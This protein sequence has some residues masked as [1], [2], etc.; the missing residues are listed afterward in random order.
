M[1]SYRARFFAAVLFLAAF[2]A[3]VRP[4]VAQVFA[5][6][7]A[8]NAIVWTNNPVG[9]VSQTWT[10]GM[11]TGFG[12][13][14]PWVLLQT[15][16]DNTHKNFAGF[17]NG[18]G[19]N[20]ATTNSSSWGTF[21]NGN[22]DGAIPLSNGTNKAVAMRGF[23]PLTTNQVFK[24]QW[25]SKGI[26]SG[27]TTNNR[28]GFALRNGMATNSYLDYDIGSRFD[29]YYA[30]GGGSFLIRDGNGITPTGI[31]F[32]SAGFNCEFTPKAGNAYRF[33]IHSA[34]DNSVVYITDGQP[35]AGSGTI[36]S[37][38]CYDL[39]C[40]DGD[41]NF[42]RMQILSTSLIPSIIVNFQPTNG[43]YFVNPAGKISFEVDSQASTVAG[44]G[45][46]L[47]LNG[48]AQALAFNTNGA[49]S[50]LFATNAA[51]LATNVAYLATV[52]ATDA[53]GNSATN[54]F[55][56]NTYQTN[57][58]WM[59]VKT[60][61]ATGNGTTKD[62][63][64]IQ[65]AINACPAGGYV[66]LHNSTFLSGTISLKGNMTLFIDPTATLLGSGSAA[67]YPTQTPP[68]SNS[69]LGNCPR[70]LVYAESCT[71]VTVTGGGTI[72]GNG[73]TNFTSGV[74][75]TRPIAIWLANCNQAVLQSI[76]I[77]DASMWT[78]VPMQTDFLIVSNL[79]INDDGLN[80]NRDG[81]DPVDCWHIT[82][83]NC[84][85]DSGDDSICLKS[86]SSRGVKDVLVKNCTVTR[87]QSNGFKFGTASTGPFT[88]ITF[89]DC[90]LQNVSHSAMAVESVDGGAISAVTFQ[91]ITFS[92]CQNAIFIVL[93][94]RG[95]ATIGSISG[96]TYRDITGSAMSDTRGC[97][98]MGELTNGVTYRVKNIL[99]D[100]V[101]IVFK[102]VLNFIPTDPPVE[103]TGQ[104]PENTIWTNLPAYGYYLRH[105][106]NVVFTN[107]YTGVSP[108]DARP[109]MTNAD[110]GNLTVYG[111]VLN[112]LPNPGNM[113]LQ[114]KYN[115]ILQSATNVNGP[116]ADVPG[117]PDPYT[118]P[119]VAGT[120]KFF[121]LRQ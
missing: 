38:A 63:A 8:G 35:L 76:N 6:D 87:S 58:L 60:F 13:T 34:V 80:G 37:V 64:A 114:W 10:N 1:K 84:T 12:W 24:L 85:I 79:S 67:D 15:V 21:A 17:Y 90:S 88:N 106:T 107:C 39:Q 92:A 41:Q 18:N 82:I 81:I 62:T 91:R 120:Q 116:Y 77:V 22:Y 3:F 119:P 59:D 111:P 105:A 14:T 96:I 100:N 54:F 61:G 70:A 30:A 83:A 115:F 29:F 97:P 121:R 57:S 31:P 51:P 46:T 118:N 75:A 40:Q 101:N 109:W 9:I 2:I 55:S 47:L 89:Q 56:F 93:G 74:E 20:I 5:Y 113:A 32:T 110:V 7:D 112:C 11:N 68:L 99:F 117:A 95:T 19:A 65:S 102:G 49:T 98:I 72:N 108:Y 66:W 42:N 36:D 104:Y 26:A 27:G 103:Y 16:R 33:V 69:Q 52:I 44:T 50:Q 25:Q 78:V 53:N 45:V 43:A 4:V 28:G 48:V 86:G 94:G 73:R 23:N 71:N